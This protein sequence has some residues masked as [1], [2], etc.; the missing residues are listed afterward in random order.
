MFI[1]NKYLPDD[2]DDYL[3]LNKESFGMPNETAFSVT[4]NY[5]FEGES[6]N[7]KR[8][9]VCFRFGNKSSWKSIYWTFQVRQ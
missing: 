8:S 5:T 7:W 9:L 2:F 3:I 6:R 4:L 1:H